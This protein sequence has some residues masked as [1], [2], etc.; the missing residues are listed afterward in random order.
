MHHSNAQKPSRLCGIHAEHP[1]EY[2][3]RQERQA[4]HVDSAEGIG[5]SV[6]KCCVEPPEYLQHTAKHFLWISAP[7]SSTNSWEGSS[8]LPYCWLGF[9]DD[10]DIS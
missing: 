9:R 4:H 3:G 7:S 2:F 5:D 10:S 8:Q 1:Q 6:H